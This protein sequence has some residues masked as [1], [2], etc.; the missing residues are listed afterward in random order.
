MSADEQRL[1][2]ARARILA[3]RKRRP[4]AT[5]ELVLFTLAR[6]TYAIELRHLRQVYPLVHLAMLP[7]AEPPLMA[8]T[9]WRGELIR[10]L[11]LTRILDV[12]QGG[13]TDRGRVLVIGGEGSVFA[14]LADRIVDVKE[15]PEKQLTP[16]TARFARSATADA[17]A[18]LDGDELIRTFA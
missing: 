9:S 17:I 11:D 13:P 10:V 7:G 14:V 18:V 5:V 15:I 8:V 12:P 16:I 6:A 2:E 3:R 1:L 4:E